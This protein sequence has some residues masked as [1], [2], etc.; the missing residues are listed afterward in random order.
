MLA[1]AVRLRPPSQ[2]Q[3][4]GFRPQLVRRDPHRWTMIGTVLRLEQP[5]RPGLTLTRYRLKLSVGGSI[6]APAPV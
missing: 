2:K 5:S 4:S 3:K 6:D 1:K